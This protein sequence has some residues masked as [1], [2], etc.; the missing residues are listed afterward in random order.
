MDL[1]SGIEFVRRFRK[2]LVLFNVRPSDPI[3]EQLTSRFDTQNVEVTTE[4]TASGRPDDIAVLSNRDRVLV[5]IDVDRLR[6]LCDHQPDTRVET[7]VAD[8]PYQ[9][10][11]GHL[12]ETTFT[13]HDAEQ[14]L[15]ASREIED[16]ARRVG[17]GTVHA[18]FQRVS[19][20][21]SQRAIYADLARQGV[22]V[23]TYGIADAAPPELGGGQVHAVN[24]DEIAE[25]WFVVFDGGDVDGQKSALLARERADD[26]F[27]GAWTYDATIVDGVLTYLEETYPRKTAGDR[28]HDDR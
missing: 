7:G 13:S 25:T 1:R 9:E 5:V 21:A 15:Y 11:L 20:I 17:E 24:T 14:L 18:G 2:E 28:V 19:T 22:D 4:R 12:K 8:G 6:E 10:V 3:S 23:H 26:E 16:R 27:Y